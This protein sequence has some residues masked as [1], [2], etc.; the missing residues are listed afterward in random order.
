[1]KI[2]FNFVSIDDIIIEIKTNDI[3]RMDELKKVFHL[4]KLGFQNIAKV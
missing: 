4:V 3:S 1:M 2:Q